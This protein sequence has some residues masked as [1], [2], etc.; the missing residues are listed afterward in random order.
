MSNQVNNP[1]FKTTILKKNKP[2]VIFSQK[3]PKNELED[4]EVFIVRHFDSKWISKLINIRT[5][6]GFKQDEFACKLGLSTSMYKQLESNKL[7]YDAK[8]AESINN[9]LNK[10]KLS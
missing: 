4:G 5:K 2:Y 6:N 7:V 8:L 3:T 10:L 1:D 9:K